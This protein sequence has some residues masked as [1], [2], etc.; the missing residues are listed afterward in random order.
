MEDQTFKN[1]L[2]DLGT[3]VKEHAREAKEQKT[4]SKGKSSQDYKSGYL[5]AWYEVVSLMQQQA[6][7]FGIP[8]ESLDLHDINPDKD[9]FRSSKRRITTA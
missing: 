4:S 8:F 5:M 9:L 2:H 1:Y 3:L 7:A 6:E